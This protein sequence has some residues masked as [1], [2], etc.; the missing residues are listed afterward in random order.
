MS[1]TYVYRLLKS[2]WGIRVTVTASAQIGVSPSGLPGAHSGAVSVLFSGP[3]AELGEEFKKEIES[4]LS[5]VE[6]EVVEACDGRGVSVT[7]EE[8]VFNQ[9]DFQLEGLLVAIIRWAEQE[10]DLPVH[11]IQESF[12]KSSN[13]YSFKFTRGF[14]WRSEGPNGRGGL[15]R[16]A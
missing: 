1:R 2:S 6:R 7:I 5:Y 11:E 16:L 10:F 8:V 13:R 3:A 15:F 9:A 14:G 4:G 12:D